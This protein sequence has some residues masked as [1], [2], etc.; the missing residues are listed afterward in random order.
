MKVFRE[1]NTTIRVSLTFSG[2]RQFT[3]ETSSKEIKKKESNVFLTRAN[4]KQ[5]NENSKLRMNHKKCCKESR[6]IKNKFI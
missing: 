3:V 5:A 1:N 6:G 4:I 2:D